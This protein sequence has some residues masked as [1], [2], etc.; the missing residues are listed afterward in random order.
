[1]IEEILEDKI[2]I[3][4]RLKR[5]RSLVKAI[6]S[7][8]AKKAI[9]AE[10][11]RKGLGEEKEEQRVD[12]NAVEM[13]KEMEKGG[14]CAISVLTDKKF[15]GSLEDLRSVKEVVNMPVLRKDFIIDEFQVYESYAN[16]ADAILLIASLLEE[17]KIRKLANLSYNLGMEVLLEVDRESVEEVLKKRLYE[18]TPLIGINNRNLKNLEVDL[19]AFEELAPKLKIL[20]REERKKIYLVAMSGITTKEDALRMFDAGADALLIGSSISRSRAEDVE[21]RVKEFVCLAA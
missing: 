19:K 10:I 16:G 18:I 7:T 4:K 2:E 11:K 14:A 12:I 15:N 1:M 6:L 21:R 13:A 9:I 8:S 17:K 3:I 20:K 5:R